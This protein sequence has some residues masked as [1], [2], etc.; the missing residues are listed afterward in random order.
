MA[1]KTITGNFNPE[2]PSSYRTFDPNYIELWERNGPFQ[3]IYDVRNAMETLAKMI[4][5]GRTSI[6]NEMPC[7]FEQSGLAHIIQAL[8]DQIHDATAWIQDNYKPKDEE[9]EAAPV[10]DSKEAAHV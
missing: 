5:R 8:S 10:S 7:E 6:C 9:K 4:H 1:E 3:R 2:N